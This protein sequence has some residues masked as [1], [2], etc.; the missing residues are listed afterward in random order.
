MKFQEPKMHHRLDEK[1]LAFLTCT[2]GAA[3]S[4]LLLV[5]LA[6]AV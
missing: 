3:A 4:A 2:L 5:V 6:A 1:F